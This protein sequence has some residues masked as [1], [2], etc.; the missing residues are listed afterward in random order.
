MSGSYYQY[1]RKDYGNSK[2]QP[3]QHVS[4]VQND[5]I[6]QQTQGEMLNSVGSGNTGGG[7]MPQ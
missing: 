4:R 5:Y 1:G 2:K 3:R 7:V 6:E